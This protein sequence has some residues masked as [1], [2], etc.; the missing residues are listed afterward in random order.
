MEISAFT[1]KCA[2]KCAVSYLLLCHHPSCM[3]S[4]ISLPFLSVHCIF[5][6]ADFFISHPLFLSPALTNLLHH[7]DFLFLCNYS[8]TMLQYC[9][10]RLMLCDHTSC[11]MVVYAIYLPQGQKS[12]YFSVMMNGSSAVFVCIQMHVRSMVTVFDWTALTRIYPSS[13]RRA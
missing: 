9:M 3:M 6:F 5:F 13:H 2:Y 4:C 10:L 12:C 11:D 8:V 7:K 1:Q